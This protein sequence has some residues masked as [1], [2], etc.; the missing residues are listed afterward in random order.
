MGRL[1]LM[2]HHSSHHPFIIHHATQP[3]KIPV[4]IKRPNTSIISFGLGPGIFRVVLPS[5]YWKH[6]CK[7]VRGVRI[8]VQRRNTGSQLQEAHLQ[9]VQFV[10]EFE[11]LYYPRRVDCI[12]FCHPCIHTLL[13]AALEVM[14]VGPGAY[15]TQFT[16]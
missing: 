6:F 1:L 11:N 10:E 16:M 4:D 14:R 5:K 12:H 8:L 15:T 2:Q 9:L 3:K 7:L 13:H